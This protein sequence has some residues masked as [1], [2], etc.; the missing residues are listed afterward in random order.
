MSLPGCKQ[1]LLAFGLRGA[2]EVNRAIYAPDTGDTQCQQRFLEGA[3]S[4]DR[5]DDVEGHADQV[6]EQSE[7][8]NEQ[9]KHHVIIGT[10]MEGHYAQEA[11]QCI[12]DKRPKVGGKRDRDRKSVV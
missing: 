6:C 9:V 3:E 12:K 11:A 1:Y 5:A 8:G 10:L 2:Q 7:A 4:E